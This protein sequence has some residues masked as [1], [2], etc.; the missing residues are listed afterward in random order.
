MI[1][2]NGFFKVYIHKNLGTSF[3][4]QFCPTMKLKSTHYKKNWNSWGLAVTHT[5]EK[6]DYKITNVSSPHTTN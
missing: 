4:Y 6:L 2:A 1:F 5:I 3:S